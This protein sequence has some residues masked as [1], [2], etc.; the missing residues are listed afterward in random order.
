MLNNCISAW[1]EVFLCREKLVRRKSLWVVVAPTDRKGG[2]QGLAGWGRLGIP[3]GYRWLTGRI[4]APT[5][6]KS[7]LGDL[8]H[9]LWL[10]AMLYLPELGANVLLA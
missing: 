5:H 4:S 9:V 1:G 8:Y 6:N 3:G 2:G 10:P 7:W